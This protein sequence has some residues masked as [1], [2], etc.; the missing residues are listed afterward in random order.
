MDH[1]SHKAELVWWDG[2]V[3]AQA[4]KGKKRKEIALLNMEDRADPSTPSG[5]G[6]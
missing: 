5:G 1:W 4:A 3:G 2:R 6:Q